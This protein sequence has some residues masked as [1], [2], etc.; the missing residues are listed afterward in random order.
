MRERA[1]VAAITAY[2]TGAG[3]LEAVVAAVSTGQAPYAVRVAED[4]RSLVQSDPSLAADPFGM[5]GSGHV[6]G[7]CQP[8]SG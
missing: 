6:A 7:L 8:E 2:A 5:F 4:T 3:P 1:L